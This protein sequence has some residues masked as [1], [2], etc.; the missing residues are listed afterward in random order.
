[1]IARRIFL[2]GAASLALSACSGNLIGP[3]EAG[4]IYPLRPAL[5][6]AGGDKV[7]WSLAIVLSDPAGGLDGDRI[8]LLQPDG[9]MDY[10]AKA[11]YPAPL[12]TLL[13]EVVVDGFE[14]SGRI[15]AVAKEQDALHA[16]YNLVLAVK[17]FETRY[18]ER[19]GIP[20]AQVTFYVNLATTHG[21]RILAGFTTTQ[22]APATA[23][24]AAA[25]AQALQQALGKAV[26]A[27]VDWTFANAPATVPGQPPGAASPDKPAE[28]LLHEMTHTRTAPQ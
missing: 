2:T 6:A 11:N 16:D 1:M 17:D 3:P 14:A 23:N 18:A 4:M 24:T 21:R 15:E 10:Y 19:D 8:A 26:A 22:T 27:I 25:A 20:V 9:S 7:H 28:Q 12:P 5:P 13:Q